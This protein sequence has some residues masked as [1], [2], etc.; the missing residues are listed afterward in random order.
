VRGALIGLAAAI[1]VALAVWLLGPAAEDPGRL[2]TQTADAGGV[3]VTVTPVRLDDDSA[4]F[5]VAFDTHTVELTV[6]A[7][8]TALFVGSVRWG[9]ATWDGD[10]A[11]GHHRSGRLFFPAQGPAAGPAVLSIGGLPQPVTFE[12]SLGPP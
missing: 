10:P 11:E 3:D 8:D 2:V 7:A 6:E 5:E 12:W 9:Q 1:L 4:L